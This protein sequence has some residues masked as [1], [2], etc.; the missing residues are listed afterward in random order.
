MLFFVAYYDKCTHLLHFDTQIDM[1]S[2]NILVVDD[3]TELRH[4]L[5]DYLRKNGYQVT[6]A[7]DGKDM[8]K[9]LE[10]ARSILSCSI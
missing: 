10:G 6:L 7:A 1:A 2:I 4:L 9:S 5:G 8:R 3:D